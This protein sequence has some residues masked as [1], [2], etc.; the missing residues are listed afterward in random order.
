MT[1][2]H[3]GQDADIHNGL[4]LVLELHTMSDHTS[5]FLISN[6]RKPE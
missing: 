1:H 6:A 2:R 3:T 4:H 5:D